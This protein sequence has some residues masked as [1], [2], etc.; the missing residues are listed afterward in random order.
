MS[1]IEARPRSPTEI[2]DSTFY[3]LRQNYGAYVTAAAIMYLPSLLLALATRGAADVSPAAFVMS[4]PVAVSVLLGWFWVA[5]TNAAMVVITSQ[6]FLGSAP[7]LSAAIKR[8]LRR[9]WP[10]L[11]SVIATSVLTFVGIIF[12]IVPGV[13]LASRYGVSAAVAAVE[14]AGPI[15]SLERASRLSRHNQVRYLNTMLMLF[16]LYIIVSI[17][18]GIILGIT[19]LPA[20]AI[21]STAIVSVFLFPALGIAHT[22]LYYDMRIRNEGYDLQLMSERLGPEQQLQPVL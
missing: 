4:T 1:G 18:L 14:D 19:G 6:I 10:V 12:L 8:A 13:Y 5:L 3:V 2:I 20:M 11:F 22:L 21:V 17:A 7:D 16:V 9:A 15:G